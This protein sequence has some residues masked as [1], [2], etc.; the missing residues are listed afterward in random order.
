MA[1]KHAFFKALVQ[2]QLNTCIPNRDIIAV[3]HSVVKWGW[4]I[5]CVSKDYQYLFS[6][7]QEPVKYFIGKTDGHNKPRLFKVLQ[8][9]RRSLLTKYYNT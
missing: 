7:D 8:K 2:R 4:R 3:K 6:I 9:Q 1:T 5:Y